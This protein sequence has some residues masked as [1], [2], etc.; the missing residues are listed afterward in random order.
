MDVPESEM[1]SSAQKRA[2]DIKFCVEKLGM[3]NS[4]IESCWRAGKVDSTKDN[5]CR[6]LIIKMSDAENADDWTKNGKGNKTESGFWIN[7]DLCDADRK[8]NFAARQ[9]RRARMTSSS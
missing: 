6:P 5:Y 3:S 4:D 9:E 8:A 2:D 7:R 1:E